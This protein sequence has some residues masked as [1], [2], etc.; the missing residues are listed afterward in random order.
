MK[1]RIAMQKKGRLTDKTLKLLDLC[2]VEIRWTKNRLMGVSTSF[3]L[4]ILLVRDDDIPNLLSSNVCDL[5]ILGENVLFE[6]GGW[7]QKEKVI[8]KLGYGC[9]RLSIATDKNT[10]WESPQDLNNQKIATSYPHLV[11]KFLKSEQI[12]AEIVEIT[13]SV[14]LTPSLGIAPYICDLVS[15]GTTLQANGLKE[16]CQIMESECVIARSKAELNDEK[17][18]LLTRLLRRIDGVQKAQTNKYVMMNAPREALSKIREILP[19]MELPSVMKLD[20]SDN[21]IAIHAVCSEPLFWDTMEKLKELGA[22]SVLVV[23]IEK[24]I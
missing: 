21:K 19:G 23:P 24:I 2:G 3:P 16:V 17:E 8:R 13:G 7:E 5:G 9:C 11:E 14:E 20:G 12:S 1:L 18:N 10:P 22:S 4:E 15:T 6:K